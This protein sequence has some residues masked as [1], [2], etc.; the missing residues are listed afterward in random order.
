MPRSQR[1]RVDLDGW[2]DEAV[3]PYALRRETFSVAMDDIY[4]LLASVNEALI[5][6]GLLRLEE[7][8]RGA[9]YSGLL[10]D[11]IAA[12]LAKH[13]QGLTKN[14]FANGHPDLLPV[15]RFTLDSAQSAEEGVEIKVTNKRGGAVDMHGERPAWLCVFRYQT[16]LETEPVI[17]RAPTRF[18]DIW[19]YQASDSAEFRHNSRGPLGTRTVTLNRLGLQRMRARWI[20]STD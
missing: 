19:L 7:S 11:L 10:S 12:S 6:R 20:Y 2:N 16:D 15:G 1:A 8:V 13:A 14:R 9:I 17:K 18:T 5:G 4:E 3:Y